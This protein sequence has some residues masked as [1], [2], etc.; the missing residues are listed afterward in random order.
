MDLKNSIQHL[1]FNEMFLRLFGRKMEE[2]LKS[3]HLLDDVDY[4]RPPRRREHHL[5][6]IEINKPII[7]THY[8]KLPASVRSERFEANAYRAYDQRKAQS[9]HGKENLEAV[10]RSDKDI[11]NFFTN[12]GRRQLNDMRHHSTYFDFDESSE[13]DEAMSMSS[14][15]Y[16]TYPLKAAAR[17]HQHESRPALCSYCKQHRFLTRNQQENLN[18]DYICGA[19]GN[20]PICL[21]CRQEICVRCKRIMRANENP[22]KQPFRLQHRKYANELPDLAKSMRDADPPMHIDNIQTDDDDN[23][24]DHSSIAEKKAPFSF[25]IDRSSLFHP[26]KSTRRQSVG[27]RHEEVPVKP[28]SFDELRRITDEKMAKLSK[29]YAEV[30]KANKTV[31]PKEPSPDAASDQEMIRKAILNSTTPHPI[32]IPQ[33]RENTKRLIEFAKELERTDSNLYGRDGRNGRD[34][35]A[36]TKNQVNFT[37]VLQDID[38]LN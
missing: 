6:S 22:V 11:Y 2:Q 34:E 30:H 21:S 31:V 12:S 23:L 14:S 15:T 38:I 16:N 7:N 37:L 8:K 36:E 3:V 25:N 10:K 28:D 17:H 29:T 4:D 24:S 26:S 13:T 35:Q 9:D 5:I 19:C 20:E 33:L 27:I 1:Y 18:N 32:T